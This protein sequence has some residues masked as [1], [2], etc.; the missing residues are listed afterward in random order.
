MR[1]NSIVIKLGATIMVLFMVILI[2]L[3]YVMD[4]IFTGFYYGQVHTHIDEVSA[5]IIT[6]LRD[7]NNKNELKLY[8][9]LA[10]H[11]N[12]EIV[13]VNNKGKVL[14][15]SNITQYSKGDTLDQKLLGSLRNNK[16][17]HQNYT[18]PVNNS[19][20]LMSGRALI[21]NN[22]FQGGVLVFSSVDAL[23][24]S[25]HQIREYLILSVIGAL[26]LA[27]GFTYFLSKK[28]SS[29]LIGMEKITR[30]I[31]KGD[32][33][34]NIEKVSED[35]V[36]S[37]AQAINDLAVELKDY[38]TNRSEFLANISHELRT[39]ISYLSGYA[40]VIRNGLY[41]NEKEKEDYLKI[42]ENESSRLVILINDLFE[43]S[44]M[45]E[46]RIEL[47][48]EWIDVEE[49]I[50]GI[51]SR[52][53]L[54][55]KEKSLALNYSSK[56]K[57]PMLLSDGMRLEQVITNLVENAIRYTN[58]GYIQIN[59]WSKKDNVYISIKDT[60]AGIP[61]KDLPLIFDRFYRVE[62]SRSREMGGTGLGLA[63]VRE[64]VKML[65]GNIEVNSKVGKGT[66]FILSLPIDVA[67]NENQ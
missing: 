20:F 27:L 33:N 61:E 53:K 67:Q 29:P 56:N 6:S 16:K 62:K 37:L 3:G 9:E 19:H 59:S 40:S 60:G 36:G 52:V 64:I 5:D 30:R 14:T 34:V 11:T 24:Q 48:K 44:K 25:T 28:L 66:E 15:S 17:I 7:L 43:L 47:Y 31:A 63:I 4:R 55:A 10:N 22:H 49:L 54:K 21:R 26:I 13:I 8:Q 18:D 23:H 46:N 32:L 50:E 45:E 39:P 1:S 2:P 42:I 58:Q 41:E 35:E 65:G 38:R 12:T 57:M 51:L